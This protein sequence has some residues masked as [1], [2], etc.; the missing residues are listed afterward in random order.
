M[1]VYFNNSIASVYFAYF[2]NIYFHF[3]PNITLF[4]FFS[5]QKEKL[6][7]FDNNESRY[8]QRLVHFGGGGA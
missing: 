8:R 5:N 6:V 3:S 2:F 1:Y 4:F 7:L